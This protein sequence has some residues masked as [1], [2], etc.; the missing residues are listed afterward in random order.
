MTRSPLGAWHYFALAPTYQPKA[1]LASP[2]QDGSLILTC[3]SLDR[4][5]SSIYDYVRSFINY[6]DL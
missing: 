1:L 5:L 3:Y 6:K 4:F 2:N